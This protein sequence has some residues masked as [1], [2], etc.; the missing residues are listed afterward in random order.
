MVS[1][2]QA[3][4]RT[5]H[6]K[7]ERYITERSIVRFSVLFGYQTFGF[8][9]FTVKVLRSEILQNLKK[10]ITNWKV[11]LN[12][13]KSFLFQGGIMGVAGRFPPAYM[14]AMVQGQALGGIIAVSINISMLAVGL[15]DVDAAFW[16]FL[17]ATVY[18]ATSLVAFMVVT[19][20]EFYQVRRFKMFAGPEKNSKITSHVKPC[21]ISLHGI[22]EGGRYQK[23][24]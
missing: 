7:S 22:W 21:Y 19:R 13:N 4:E 17:I 10:K 6:S 12:F 24:V 20:T 14:G 2:I 3:F 9:T 1:E 18:L 5:E 15:D 16:D 23:Y 11:H 8:R